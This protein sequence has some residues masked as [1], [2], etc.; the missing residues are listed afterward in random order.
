MNMRFRPVDCTSHQLVQ[1]YVPGLVNT[2][3]FGTKPEVGWGVSTYPNHVSDPG[4]NRVY[5]VDQELITQ[6]LDQ[7]LTPQNGSCFT[8]PSGKEYSV[9]LKLFCQN[10]DETGEQPFAL[11][12]SSGIELTIESAAPQ[13]TGSN[14]VDGLVVGID[15]VPSNNAGLSLQVSFC[16]ANITILPTSLVSDERVASLPPTPQVEGTPLYNCFSSDPQPVNQYVDMWGV[17]PN[18]VNISSTSSS[19]QPNDLNGFTAFNHTDLQNFTDLH[20]IAGQ[21]TCI[22]AGAAGAQY[23]SLMTTCMAGPPATTQCCVDLATDSQAKAANLPHILASICNSIEAASNQVCQ[24]FTWDD[25]QQRGYFKGGP[26]DSQY[27]L[28][29]LQSN[30]TLCNSPNVTTWV[31][32]AAWMGQGKNDTRAM[33]LQ[34]LGQGKSASSGKSWAKK[35]WSIGATIAGIC[36]SLLAIAVWVLLFNSYR[37]EK[38]MLIKQVVKHLQASDICNIA[39]GSAAAVPTPNPIMTTAN[40]ISSS[41]HLLLDVPSSGIVPGLTMRRSAPADPFF[42]DPDDGI[43]PSEPAKDIQQVAKE[44]TLRCLQRWDGFMGFR[45]S[46]D[47]LGRQSGIWRER[48]DG[49]RFASLLLAFRKLNAALAFNQPGDSGSLLET[50]TQSNFK[51]QGMIVSQLAKVLQ[52]I[53]TEEAQALPD[54]DPETIGINDRLLQLAGVK[55]D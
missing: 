22:A 8:F 1:P 52:S 12:K 30:F 53:P 31:L 13:Q 21:A 49:V 5:A 28:D 54:K 15:Q 48:F 50:W 23:A 51:H 55:K 18:A 47:S 46:T 29:Q 6:R 3:V 9:G 37:L 16:L 35:V 27:K 34:I 19:Y 20:A 2:T 40:S 32:N 26:V 10:C 36:S 11:S 14:F 4:A 33:S 38:K 41:G 44:I 45:A 7:N 24:A 39:G 42:Y 17:Y 25:E 43:I